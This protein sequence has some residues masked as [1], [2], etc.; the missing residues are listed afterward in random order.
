MSN[1]ITL[2]LILAGGEGQRV[3]RQNKGLLKLQGKTLT[4][5]ILE[6]LTPQ[7]DKVVISANADVETYRSLVPNVYVDNPLYSNKGP[8]AGILTVSEQL[9]EKV[10][11]IQVV[12]CDTPFIPTNLVS[13]LKQAL[14][15]KPEYDIAYATT[16]LCDHPSIFLCKAHI[17]SQLLDHLAQ[18]KL[19]IKSWL[20][21]HSVISV[22]FDDE[23]AFTNI[24]YLE[25]LEQYQ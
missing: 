9:Y 17:N 15:S 1:E 8:L 4:Q 13:L 12:P 16:T 18:G 24:N 3:G 5:H 22:H 6:R 23:L 21:K 7:V 10:N 25:T 20:F 2:G 14:L 19:S 11:Y